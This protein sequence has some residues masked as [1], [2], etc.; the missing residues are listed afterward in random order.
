MGINFIN[1]H[2]QPD[3]AKE[4][5]SSKAGVQC[6]AREGTT[7]EIERVEFINKRR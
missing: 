2:L 7:T 5:T 1:L 3:S 6:N 4:E